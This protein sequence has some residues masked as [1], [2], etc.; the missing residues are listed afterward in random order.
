MRKEDLKEI[1]EGKYELEFNHWHK[2]CVEDNDSPKDRYEYIH[3][4]LNELFIYMQGYLSAIVD[5]NVVLLGEYREL[6]DFNLECWEK[7]FAKNNKEY[8]GD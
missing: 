8:Y 2:L 5:A 1:I 7:Y 6:M 4:K 3:N